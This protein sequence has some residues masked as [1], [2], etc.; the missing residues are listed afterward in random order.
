MIRFPRLRPREPTAEQLADERA[1]RYKWVF[2]EVVRTCTACAA[3]QV[4]PLAHLP[5]DA[6]RHI[7][8]FLP[9]APPPPG[10]PA[11]PPPPLLPHGGDGAAL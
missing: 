9:H 7:T 6:V 5:P 8:S 10:P 3:A 4:A 11:P 2:P 1:H